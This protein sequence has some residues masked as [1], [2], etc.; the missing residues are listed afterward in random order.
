MLQELGLS[1]KEKAYTWLANFLT[2][3]YHPINTKHL[4]RPALDN[5][6]RYLWIQEPGKKAYVYHGD[7]SKYPSL[8]EFNESNSTELSIVKSTDSSNAVVT[9]QKAG[10][11]RLGIENL[12][13][14]DTGEEEEEAL[15][16][17]VTILTKENGMLTK[18][19]GS[20]EELVVVVEKA[21]PKFDAMIR[22][23]T[24]SEKG[25]FWK[26]TDAIQRS[27]KQARAIRE[28]PRPRK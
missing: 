22:K 3:G 1:K 19:V 20:C 12:A 25:K 6:G 17:L 10:K 7:I 2:T 21:Q 27:R 18:I 24:A 8:A 4:G 23:A 16:L 28:E 15:E 26:A 9:P 13:S 14:S 5:E 11:G